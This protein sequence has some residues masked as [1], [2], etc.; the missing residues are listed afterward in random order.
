[1]KDW[2]F[3]GALV[4]FMGFVGFKS[5]STEQVSAGLGCVSAKTLH[6]P[7][8]EEYTSPAVARACARRAFA[9]GL[10]P[11]WRFWTFA[12]AQSAGKGETPLDWWV[13]TQVYRQ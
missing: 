2:I 3:I 1:M 6:F 9:E 12:G 7:A 10:Q 13:R 8:V 11:Q 4:L 5:C